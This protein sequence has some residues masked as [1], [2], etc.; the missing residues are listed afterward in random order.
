[1]ILRI[2]VKSRKF[3]LRHVDVRIQV[4]QCIIITTA[5]QNAHSYTSGRFKTT[6]HYSYEYVK[7]KVHILATVRNISK[8]F[9]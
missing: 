8:K 7:I 9:L 5:L 1:M 4:V 2:S 3:E 6:T